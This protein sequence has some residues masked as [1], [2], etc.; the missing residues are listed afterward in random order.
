MGIGLFET[1][2]TYA[3]LGVHRTGTD[4]DAKTAAWFADHLRMLGG[5]V[6]CPPYT[7]D[8]FNHDVTLLADGKKIESLPLFYRF[9]GRCQTDRILVAGLAMDH[10]DHG[11]DT[12]IEVA[13]TKA[14]E[15]GYDALVLATRGDTGALVAIN[16]QPDVKGDIPVILVPGHELKH[17]K[18]ASLSV[19]YEAS[20]SP[21]ESVNVIGSF[22][23]SDA[24]AR[25]VLTTP[26]SGW[27]TCAG[28]RGAG[29][30]LLLAL[31]EEFAERV[32]MTVV[33]A[34]G[35]EL[36]MLG[37]FVSAGNHGQRAERVF[38]IGSCIGARGDDG[39]SEVVQL[40]TD[41]DITV[42]VNSNR[43]NK[44]I[45]ALSRL[46]GRL[47]QRS[48]VERQGGW[49]GESRCWA[50]RTQEMISVAGASSLFH[51]TEDV[52]ERATTPELLAHAYG[53]ISDAFHHFSHKG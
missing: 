38:H 7:F 19:A 14:V 28:E 23:P 16:Q 30:A 29:I 4:V 26:L 27:F 32:P 51:T 42:C 21:A 41:V 12:I 48:D 35:H 39:L 46:G 17:L 24:A 47:L 15:E 37:G 43:E 40:T 49:V 18:N 1:V 25:L 53:S 45:N 50:G 36:G 52:P 8:R 20:V 6:D 10:A 31:V 2:Y 3:A 34:T 5:K 9:V 44:V 11:M 13:C 22:G 33:G